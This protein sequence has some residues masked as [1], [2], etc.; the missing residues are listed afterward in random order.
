VIEDAQAVIVA[1]SV[2]D[3][4][5]IKTLRGGFAPAHATVELREALGRRS[6]IDDSTNRARP[7]WTQA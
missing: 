3:W 1:L 7:H 6:I 2:R 5:G 4:R